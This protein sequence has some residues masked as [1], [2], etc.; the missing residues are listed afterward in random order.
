[1]QDSTHLPSPLRQRAKVK[2]YSSNTAA[3]LCRTLDITGG[4]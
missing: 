4:A 1:M 2:T 3:L